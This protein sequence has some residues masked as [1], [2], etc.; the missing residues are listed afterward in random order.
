M[1]D[2]SKRV[3]FEKLLS[4]A[5]DLFGM[6]NDG[7]DGDNLMHSMENAKS[8]RSFCETNVHETNISLEGKVQSFQPKFNMF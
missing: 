7:K 8:L 2:T 3:D 6:L 5:N 4:L 1:R